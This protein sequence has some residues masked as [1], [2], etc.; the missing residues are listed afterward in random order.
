MYLIDLFRSLNKDSFPEKIFSDFAFV[1]SM[2]TKFATQQTQFC[3]SCVD[4]NLVESLLISS[5]VQGCI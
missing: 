4:K 5:L 1:L 3:S 2:K